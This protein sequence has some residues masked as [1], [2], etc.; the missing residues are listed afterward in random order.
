MDLHNPKITVFSATTSIGPK[1][2]L[3]VRSWLGLSPQITVV[4]FS[5]HPSIR[6]FASGFGPRVL[7]DSA[8]D[9]TFLGTP[10]FHSMVERSHAFDTDI[11]V[12]VDSQTVL[13]PDLVPTLSF[14][15]KLDRNWLLAASLQ[16]TSFFPF[17]LGVD[18]QHWLIE[19]G[20][21]CRS[22]LA[23]IGIVK[24]GVCLWLGTQEMCL[25]TMESFPLL[26]CS[27]IS[28]AFLNKP[29][30]MQRP[31]S[32]L[33]MENRSWEAVANLHL[34]ALYGSLLFHEINYSTL[35]KLMKCDDQYLFINGTDHIARN[36]RVLAA[37]ER[38]RVMGCVEQIKLSKSMLNCSVGDE[39]RNL[40]PLEYQAS[41][42]SLL[43]IAADETQTVVL[44]IAGYSYKDMLMSWVC[45][46][47]RLRITNFIICALDQE[48]YEFSVLQ[49]LPV[50]HDLSAPSNISFNDCHFGT[51]CFQKVTKVKSRTV[52]KILKMGYNVL[53]SDVDVYWFEN[54]LQYVRSFGPTT[55]VAQSDR[56]QPNRTYKLA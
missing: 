26:V 36:R 1:Q 7:V 28:G 45:R 35:A 54:P 17:K 18:G 31:G 10:F 34:G 5:Q 24:I 29:D 32:S 12:F 50:F 44:A 56:I 16:D 33:A 51:K 48:T 11:I 40:Q 42:E 2:S 13:L 6:S 55:L 9:F 52:L 21:S 3:A 22:C 15:H 49:G 38:K 8:I 14:A 4:L 20:R 43:A 47:R 53:L 39:L 23:R 25:Y 19:N 46:L 30:R 27:V 41:L 37:Q